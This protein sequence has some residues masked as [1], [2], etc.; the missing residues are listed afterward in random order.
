MS[1]LS[2]RVKLSLNGTAQLELST[3]G[4]F[5]SLGCC[6]METPMRSVSL[7]QQRASNAAC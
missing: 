4:P 1:G 3:N 6:S 5:T 7:P 2:G